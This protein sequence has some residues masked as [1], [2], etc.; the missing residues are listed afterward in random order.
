MRKAKI[1]FKGLLICS[2][3]FKSM[4]IQENGTTALY[5]DIRV[6]GIV[7]STHLIMIED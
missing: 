4:E 7:P 1:Y 3:L 5:N 6:V 2:V